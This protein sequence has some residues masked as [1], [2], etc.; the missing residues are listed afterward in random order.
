MPEHWGMQPIECDCQTRRYEI[1]A[2]VVDY[3]RK[4]SLP[5]GS[6]YHQKREGERCGDDQPACDQRLHAA[7]RFGLRGLFATN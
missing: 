6:R 1:A 2:E 3:S 4:A 7:L 5:Y